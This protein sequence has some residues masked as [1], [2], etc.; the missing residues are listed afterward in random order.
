MPFSRLAGVYGLVVVTFFAIDL[1]WL[2]LAIPRLYK[3]ELGD[4]LRKRPN[5]PGAIAFYLIYLV[6]L[7][8]LA[9]GPA[10][11]EGSAW[12]A[13]WRGSLFGL[14]AYMTYDL[15][16]QTTLKNWPLKITVIDIIWGVVINSVVSVVG[17]YGGV[18]MGL[19]SPPTNAI[20]WL[21]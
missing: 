20:L 11:Q 5:V 13:L 12:S 7:V 6:G 4:R 2:W 10:L 18:W 9:I 19:A 14:I 17:F 21:L 3:P 15:T 8:A 1:V 16:N